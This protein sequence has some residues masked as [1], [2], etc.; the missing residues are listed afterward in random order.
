M[1]QIYANGGLIQIVVGI[2][3]PT[4]PILFTLKGYEYY[5]SSTNYAFSFMG[6]ASFQPMTI[7][8]SQL[9]QRGQLKLYPFFTKIYS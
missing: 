6:Q 2:V 7:S 5:V 4:T 9:M 1:S 8:G 3:N